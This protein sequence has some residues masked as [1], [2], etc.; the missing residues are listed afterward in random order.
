MS[1][2]FVF[3]MR[4]LTLHRNLMWPLRRYSKRKWFLLSRSHVEWTFISPYWRILPF[5]SVAIIF[6][7]VVLLLKSCVRRWMFWLWC[8]YLDRYLGVGL[9]V[10]V[11]LIMFS[12]NGLSYLGMFIALTN[13]TL[14]I[15]LVLSKFILYLVLWWCLN[16]DRF[17]AIFTIIH[18]TK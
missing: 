2:I 10:I 1:I 12:K 14:V 16:R 4:Y 9:P 7:T 13:V 15:P 5:H 18:A 8:H 11:F 3:S 17:F 6:E